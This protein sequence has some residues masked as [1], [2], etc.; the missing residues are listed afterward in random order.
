MPDLRFTRLDYHSSLFRNS[1]KVPPPEFDISPAQIFTMEFNFSLARSWMRPCGFFN[2]FKRS[3]FTWKT[4][5]VD[6]YA[7][8]NAAN[9]NEED[10]S[11]C[12]WWAFFSRFLTIQRFRNILRL[13]WWTNSWIWWQVWSRVGSGIANFIICTANSP[14]VPIVWCCADFKITVATSSDY[15]RFFLVSTIRIFEIFAWF[16]SL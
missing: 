2:F 9:Y 8:N 3:H 15:C 10:D 4:T 11:D 16:D 12:W 14:I 5:Y 13:W 6:K 7:R 1:P